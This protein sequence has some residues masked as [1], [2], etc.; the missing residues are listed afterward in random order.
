VRSDQETVQQTN[1]LAREL[2][3]LRGYVVPEG[4]RFDQSHHPRAREAWEGARAA[5]LM[6]TDTDPNDALG[7]DEEGG[8]E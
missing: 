2:Y 8:A 4:Y 5:Q 1:I 3:R 7:E 6:L